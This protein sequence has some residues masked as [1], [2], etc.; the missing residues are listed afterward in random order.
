MNLIG[1][2]L[3]VFVSIESFQDVTLKS[4]ILIWVLVWQ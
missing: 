3:I 4:L 1:L 2:L